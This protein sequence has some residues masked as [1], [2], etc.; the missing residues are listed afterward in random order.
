VVHSWS[1]ADSC[2]LISRCLARYGKVLVVDEVVDPARAPIE[3]LLKDLQLM[4]FS[5]GRHRGLQEY[6]QMFAEA[7]ARLAATAPIGRNE[8]LME[9][10][11]AS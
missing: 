8:L 9:G 11:P 4:V 7:G 1:D 2:A 3:V 6:R 5:D 10:V